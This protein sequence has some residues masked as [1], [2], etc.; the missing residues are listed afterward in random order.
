MW[1]WCINVYYVY[2]CYAQVSQAKNTD[3]FLHSSFS[4]PKIRACKHFYYESLAGK[5][6][7]HHSILGRNAMQKCYDH[8]ASETRFIKSE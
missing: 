8:T 6:Q 7:Q 5:K 4:M 3:N 1:M 2:E